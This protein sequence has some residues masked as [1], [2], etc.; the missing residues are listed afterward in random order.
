MLSSQRLWPRSWS[1]RVAFVCGLAIP[2]LLGG[3]GRSPLARR[4]FV[5]QPD[6]RLRAIVLVAEHR[7]ARR[8]EHEQA[9]AG[10]LEPE[11]ARGERAQEVSARE[12]QH[13]AVDRA[14]PRDHAV[15]A[16]ADLGRG[17]AAGAAVAEEP[18]VGALCVDLGAGATLVAAVVPLDEVAI[19]LGRRP[20]ARERA[21]ARGALQG[22]GEDLA[23]G[24]ALQA[25]ADPP[26]VL[27]PALSQRQ[28]G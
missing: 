9:G 11:P 24:E 8:P 1:R 28:I 13:V 2:N 6:R 20:E 5:P 27:L 26:R 23:E 18:P 17:F 19:D 7:E 3:S 22:A 15:G 4:H 21:G 14:K 16:R 25:A 12:E 10:G